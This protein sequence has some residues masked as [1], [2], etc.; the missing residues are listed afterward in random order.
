MLSLNAHIPNITVLER[1]YCITPEHLKLQ[2]ALP[3]K[4]LFNG[5]I[6]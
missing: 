5:F 1:V 4:S 3:V 2:D 6:L